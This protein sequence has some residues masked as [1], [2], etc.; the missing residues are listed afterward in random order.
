MPYIT[1]VLDSDDDFYIKT[2]E[3]LSHN[4]YWTVRVNGDTKQQCFE[5]AISFLKGITVSGLG[6]GQKDAQEQH[7]LETTINA[8]INDMKLGCTKSDCG[9]NASIHYQ[10]ID[11]SYQGYDIII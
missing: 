2:A 1:M 6:Y 10:L 3:R 4:C 11:E 5:K 8:V 7:F 9:G